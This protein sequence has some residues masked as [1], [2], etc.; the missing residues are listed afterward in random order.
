MLLFVGAS[1]RAQR[2][3]KPVPE[4]TDPAQSA[5]KESSLAMTPAVACLSIDSQGNYVPLPGAAL[6][7]EEKLVIYYRPINYQLEYDGQ[8]YSI[9]L[10]QDG[11]LRARGKKKVLQTKT[12]MIDW[13]WKG[14][15][16]LSSVYMRTLVALKGIPPGEYELEIILRDRLATGEPTARQTLSFRIVPPGPRDERGELKP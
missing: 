1:G 10:V 11:V 8:N 7:N 13:E 4:P 12:N 6:S 16:P 3:T 15:Q 9:H 5:S 2:V 14:R